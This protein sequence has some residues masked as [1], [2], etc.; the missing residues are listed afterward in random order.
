[1]N[2]VDPGPDA[3]YFRDIERAF[4]ER[5]GDPL[6][7][8]NAD[9]V[10]LAKL[11]KKGI[12][13][14]VVLRG[15]TDAF[16]AHEHSFARRQKIR[17]LRFCEN[18]IDAAV[19]R[20]RRALQGDGPGARAVKTA[21]ETLASAVES[22]GSGGEILRQSVID[23]ASA[24]RQIANDSHGVADDEIDRRLEAVEARLFESALTVIPESERQAIEAAARAT[25]AGYVNRMPARVYED[26]IVE[27]V[28]RRVLQRFGL[29]RLLLS[30]VS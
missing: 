15:I 8:S 2:I 13:M 18:E 6:F 7:I 3:A 29:P 23:A 16:D 1:M 20:Y 9:W 19:A 25:T 21:L 28:R 4:V 26:L 11:R 12:P 22:S 14:R 30:E 24:I 10:Y 27:S 5:R 17:T